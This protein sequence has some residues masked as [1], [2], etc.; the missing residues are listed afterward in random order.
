MHRI[1]PS[2]PVFAYLN[3]R[4]RGGARKERD[5]TRPCYQQIANQRPDADWHAERAQP[6]QFLAVLAVVAAIAAPA[7]ARLYRY[8]AFLV[9][10]ASGDGGYATIYHNPT[11]NRVVVAVTLK[12][13]AAV[14]WADFG[15][16][17]PGATQWNVTFSGN[18][19]SNGLYVFWLPFTT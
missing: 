13:A 2:K 4:A 16:T 12:T 5:L 8:G 9:D 7:H 11:D 14:A 10:P 19:V 17:A 3:S 15:S 18:G 6:M 1:S